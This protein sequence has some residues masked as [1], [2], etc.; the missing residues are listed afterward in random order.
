MISRDDEQQHPEERGLHARGAVGLRRTVV[1]V[2]VGVRA[3]GRRRLP[4]VCAQAA[5]SAAP[6]SATRCARPG[7]PSALAH[8]LDELCPHPPERA[9]GQRRDHDL[10]DVEVLHGVHRRRVG[11]GVADHAGGDD[12]RVERS[13]PA[14]GQARARLAHGGGPRRRSCG[15]TTMK[16]RGPSVGL[17]LQALDQLAARRRSGWPPRASRRTAGPRRARSTTTCSTGSPVASW[18]RSIRSR[19]SQPEDVAGSVETMISSMA[20]LARPRPSRR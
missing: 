6:R 3:G 10:R 9:L 12:R 1:V 20:G 15:T 5:V 7:L 17:R 2:V 8:A 11:I 16:R 18:R 14:G 4:S 13:G 19:R